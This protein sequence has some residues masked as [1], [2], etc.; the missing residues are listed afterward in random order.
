[1]AGYNTQAR[2]WRYT[3]IEDDDVG[4]AIPTGTILKEPVFCRIEQTKASQVLL[5]QGLEIPDMF[6]G[7]LY[8]TGEPLDI[9]QN[10]QLE[11]TYPPISPHYN[12]RF[13]I[14][15]YRQSSHQDARRFVEV[16]MRRHDT[17]RTEELQ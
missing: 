9:R 14:I 3:T 15:A 12:R 11:V 10:D 6:Q 16:T 8:Y 13:R 5:E 1:M 17:S 2:L 4:G 7:Y